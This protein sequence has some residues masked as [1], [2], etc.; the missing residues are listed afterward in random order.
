[1][2]NETNGLHV[3]Q[4]ICRVKKK[5][6]QLGGITKDKQA[7][8]GDRYKFRG[9][10]DMYNVLC[11]MTADEG[12]VML[13]RVVDSNVT[14]QTNHKG[15][16]QT[17]VHLT[18]EI[19]LVSAVDGSKAMAR[20]IGEGIDTGDKATGKGQSY[21]YKMGHIMAF[22]IPTHGESYD[23][24][25]Y[26]TRVAPQAQ[27]APPPP[28]QAAPAPQQQESPPRQRQRR[29]AMPNPE[30]A[31]QQNGVAPNAGAM[32]F[33]ETPA[34]GPSKDPAA[35]LYDTIAQS[36]TFAVLFEA[37][38]EADRYQEPA[39]GQLFVALKARTAELFANA[40]SMKDVQDGFPL[41][42]ALGQPDE[43]K[44]AANQAYA[45]FRGAS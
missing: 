14:Y 12:L 30:P 7:E 38:K 45:K 2:A 11:E 39:R 18:M 16:L 15:T 22:Q 3:Y 17:H 21:A 4:A 32:P 33:D 1:M 26:D 13:P 27:H 43:L 20:T 25:A 35:G 31:P 10:D 6:A 5:L 36:N 44:R 34:P 37:A 29:N 8:Y 28:Q 42:Q 23:N 19:D 40:K 9:I 24:E 41:V